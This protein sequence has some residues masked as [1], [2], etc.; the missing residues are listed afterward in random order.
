M[1]RLRNRKQQEIESVQAYAYDMA[2]LFAQTH[3]PAASQSDMFLDNLKP[4]LQRGF[5]NTCPENLHEAIKKA[6]F[7]ESQDLAHSPQKLKALQE[8]GNSSKTQSSAV[9]EPC[10]T[11]KDLT[12]HLSQAKPKTGDRDVRPPR[13]AEQGDRPALACFKCG[14]VGLTSVDCPTAE[15]AELCRLQSVPGPG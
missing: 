4:S 12:L 14:N 6:K 5:I 13:R 11:M 1:L 9:D 8:Q 2:L 15:G 7:L 10:R 3:T